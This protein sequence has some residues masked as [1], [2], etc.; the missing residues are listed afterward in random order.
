MKKNKNRDLPPDALSSL[1]SFLLTGQSECIIDGKCELVY[2]SEKCISF[3]IFYKSRIFSI[4]GEHLALSCISQSSCAV[5]GKIE[6]LE[7]TDKKS[8]AE[9]GVCVE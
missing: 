6:R 3:D 1:P 2:Y 9:N 4:H 5:C 8:F 7:F